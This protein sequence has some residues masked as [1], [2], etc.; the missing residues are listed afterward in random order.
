MNDEEY[1]KLRELAIILALIA[2]LLVCGMISSPQLIK[3]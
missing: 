3:P 1:Y 2:F